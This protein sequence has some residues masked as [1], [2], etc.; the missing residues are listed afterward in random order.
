[1]G[2]PHGSR[3]GLQA[4]GEDESDVADEACAIVVL[5][6]GFALISAN[7]DLHMQDYLGS[8]LLVTYSLPLLY[9][10]NN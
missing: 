3:G 10:N 2:N 9:P 4:S 5:D 7:L 1:M 6:R 8:Y